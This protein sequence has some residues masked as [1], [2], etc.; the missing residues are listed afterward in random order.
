MTRRSY[1][2]LSVS[3]RNGRLTLEALSPDNGNELERNGARG[4]GDTY[5]SFQGNFRYRLVQTDSKTVLWERWQSEDE[6]SPVSGLVSDEGYV[7]VRANFLGWGSDELLFIDPEG[8]KRLVVVVAVEGYTADGPARS[9]PKSQSEH[10]TVVWN[11]QHVQPTSAGPMWTAGSFETFPCSSDASYFCLRTAWGRR[12]VVDLRSMTP[13][14]DSAPTDDVRAMVEAEERRHALDVLQNLAPLVQ[15]GDAD[16]SE[17]RRVEGALVVAMA[18]KISEAAPLLR[19]LQLAR[20]T[21]SCCS[22]SV[23]GARWHSYDNVIRSL[24][25]LALR[26]IGEEPSPGGNYS[27]A[28]GFP[29]APRDEAATAREGSVSTPSQ[30]W[31]LAKATPSGSTARWVLSNLGAPDFIRRK[32]KKV[33]ERYVWSEVWEYDGP[34]TT[35]RLTW[36]FPETSRREIADLPREVMQVDELTAWQERDRLLAILGFMRS[37]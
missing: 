22:C 24:A 1:P 28:I 5:R 9:N 25:R 2:D 4:K 37:S 34:A 13:L 14:E 30:A 17:R 6:G 23:L 7:V 36:S 35:T 19:Q 26:F 29:G 31:E 15:A 21:G 10:A 11:D 18:Q 12:L 27:F 32:S 20:S 3:S 33:D 8:K 16:R